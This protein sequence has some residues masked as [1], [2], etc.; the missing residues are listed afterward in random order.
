MIPTEW[1]QIKVFILLDFFTDNIL[2]HIQFNDLWYNLQQ[3]PLVSNEKNK[4]KSVIKVILIFIS[5]KEET[6]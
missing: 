1:T 5:N 3:A 2:M 6:A 4:R